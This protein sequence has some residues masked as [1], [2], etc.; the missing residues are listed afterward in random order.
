MTKFILTLL[1]ISIGALSPACDASVE[2]A[3]GGGGMG[4]GS[5]ECPL[6]PSALIPASCLA[7]VKTACPSVYADLC[8]ADCGADEYGA[9]CLAAQNE[10]GTCISTG[11]PCLPAC[12][13]SHGSAYVGGAP[14]VGGGSASGGSTSPHGSS[15]DSAIAGDSA[16]GAGGDSAAFAEAG[17][18]SVA[19]AAGSDL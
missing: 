9:A 16:G 13:R 11:S 19:G 3:P 6:P 12:G 7:C 5:M 1:A 14:G 4:G 10:L 18:T 2:N 8:G 17:A 15:G